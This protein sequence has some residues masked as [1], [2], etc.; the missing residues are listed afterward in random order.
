MRIGELSRRTGV[1]ERSL[2][3]YEQQGL[4]AAT[5]TPNGQRQYAETAVDRVIHIQELFAAGL[6]SNTIAGLLPCMRDTD[7]GPARESTPRLVAE[8]RAERDRLDRAMRELAASRDVLDEVIAAASGAADES[9][10]ESRRAGG[11]IGTV[12]PL[13]DPSGTV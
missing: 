4:L 7:G 9:M 10:A 12:L 1:S 2:R 11:R 5:R 3:Y 6:R 13:T 8:L